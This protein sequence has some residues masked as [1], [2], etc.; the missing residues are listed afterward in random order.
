MVPPEAVAER[1]TAGVQDDYGSGHS[2]YMFSADVG[3]GTTA[4]HRQ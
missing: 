3:R 2:D 1:V 4:K